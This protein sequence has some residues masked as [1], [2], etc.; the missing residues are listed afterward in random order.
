MDSWRGKIVMVTGGSAGLGK[1]IAFSFARREAHV[2]LTARDPDRL[3]S[4]CQALSEQ[5][6]SVSSMAMDVTDPI[7]VATGVNNIVQEFGRLDALINNVG[8]STRVEL[9]DADPDTF[10]DLF[11]VN[12]F[13]V[14]NCTRAA[15]PHLVPTAGHVVNIGSLS[16]KTAWPF[17]APYTTSKFAVAGYTHQL[18]VE[19]PSEVHYMLVCP[20]PIQREDA[21]QRYSHESSG[22]PQEAQMPGAGAKLRGIPPEKIADLIV[23]GCERRQAELIIPWKTR[24]LFA[25]LAIHPKLGDWIL[26]KFAH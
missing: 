8:K 15:L 14:L 7:Q 11:E 20:G 2:V 5:G 1:A 17:M 6:L 4:T 22:L 13:S 26:G 10:R 12:F 19:G 25:V 18:R 9:Q 16:A 24:I 3:Q 21:G 23:K